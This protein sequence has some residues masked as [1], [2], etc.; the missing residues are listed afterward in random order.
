DQGELLGYIKKNLIAKHRERYYNIVTKRYIQRS[1]TKHISEVCDY[2]ITAGKEKGHSLLKKIIKSIGPV[3]DTLKTQDLHVAILFINGYNLFPF[4][5][6]KYIRNNEDFLD[7]AS[8]ALR[9]FLRDE[10]L[11][12]NPIDMIKELK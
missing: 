1:N 4:V 7:I 3:I 5:K 9:Y 2:N 8:K 6:G 12:K 10:T 11:P